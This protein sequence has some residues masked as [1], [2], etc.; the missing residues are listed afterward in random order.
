[1]LLYMC[2]EFWK[3]L[4]TSHFVLLDQW[5]DQL[6]QRY[7]LFFSVCPTGPTTSRC[8]T[9]MGRDYAFDEKTDSDMLDFN[10]LVIG[11]DLPLVQ[12]QRPEELPMDLSA[13]IQI[14][15]SDRVAV[16]YRRWLKEIATG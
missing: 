8:F 1:M 12:S 13:E 7:L 10:E 15:G 5:I 4:L 11:Q 3:L 2:I 6:E 16:E 9:F 14:R